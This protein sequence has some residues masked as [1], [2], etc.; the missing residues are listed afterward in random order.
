M[1]AE[2]QWKNEYSNLEVDHRFIST[3][4]VPDVPTLEA[5]NPTPK[6]LG[7]P[8]FATASTDL[9]CE[10]KKG[11]QI[12]WWRKKWLFIFVLAVLVAG[13]V[14]GGAV[15]GSQLI[16]QNKLEQIKSSSYASVSFS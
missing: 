16:A 12:P 7:A 14:V 10:D 3:L 13:G 6:Y 2:S 5:V 11:P 8:T 4:E 15:G 1:A 9:E